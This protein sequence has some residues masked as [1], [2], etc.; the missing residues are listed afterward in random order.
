M[1]SNQRIAEVLTRLMTGETLQQVVLEQ[2][3]GISHRTCQRDL[4]YIRRALADYAAGRLVEDEGAYHLSRQS[5]QDELDMVLTAS[6]ILLG[7][8]ALSRPELTATLNYL[9]SGLSPTMQRIVRQQLTVP[10]G[11]YTPVSNAQPLLLRLREVA[12]CISRSQKM[13]FVYQSSE[14]GAPRSQIHHAQPVTLFFETYYFYVA[15]LSV[16]HGG[17]W[18]YR[19]DRMTDILEKHPGE[20]LDYATRFSLQEHRHYTYLL[21]SGSL[22]Q[23]RFIYRNNIQTVLDHFPDSRI[24]KQNADGSYVVEAYVKVDGAML[25]LLSQGTGLKVLSPVSLVN[26]MRDTLTAARNQYEE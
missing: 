10:R 24:V 13:V 14:P 12:A 21:D 26:R 9:S 2:H 5:D 3:Y 7:S 18:L 6:N 20:K 22:T 16:E 8:R 19:L 25:W 17:Y 15:M 23:I 4:A 11:S 1:Q